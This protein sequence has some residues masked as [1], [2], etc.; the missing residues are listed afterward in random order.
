MYFQNR[1]RNDICRKET[2][3][4]NTNNEISF[5]VV[6]KRGGSLMSKILQLLTP[7]SK[8]NEKNNFLRG[9]G[10]GLG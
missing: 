5:F 1:K 3:S 2:E 6:E 7:K 10:V 9:Y 4:R 8:K